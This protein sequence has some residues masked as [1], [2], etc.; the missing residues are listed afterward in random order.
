M[1]RRM[2]QAPTPE[3]NEDIQRAVE[4]LQAFNK[5]MPDGLSDEDWAKVFEQ[6]ENIPGSGGGNLISARAS[7]IVEAYQNMT[8]IPLVEPPKRKRV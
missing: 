3:N 1:A 2:E 7:R 8:G 4:A 5:A 6:L